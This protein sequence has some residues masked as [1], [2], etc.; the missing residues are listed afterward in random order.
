MSKFL[1]IGMM[2]YLAGMYHKRLC[3]ELCW[4]RMKKRA[5]RMMKRL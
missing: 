1:M 2:G 4:S 5:H 3:R